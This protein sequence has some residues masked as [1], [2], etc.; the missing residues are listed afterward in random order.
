MLGR[1]LK[2][3]DFFNENDDFDRFSLI[4]DIPRVEL[5]ATISSINHLIKSPLDVNFNNSFENQV[6]LIDAIF[7]THLNVDNRKYIIGFIKILDEIFKNKKGNVVLFTRVSCLYALNEIILTDKIANEKVENYVFHLPDCENIFK[8]LLLNNKELLNYSANYNDEMSS[9]NLGNDFFKAFM[10]K[11][12]PHN[13]YYY[14]QNPINLLNRAVLLFEYLKKT[15]NDELSE[16]LKEYQIDSPEEF[17][18]IIGQFFMS[19]G[20]IPSLQCFKVPLTDVATITRLD[21][22]SQR[23]AGRP[24]IGLKKFEFL[25]IKKSPFYKSAGEENNIYLLMDNIFFIEKAYDLFYWDFFFDKLA[26]GLNQRK[27]ERALKKWGGVVGRFF[28]E[29]LKSILKYSFSEHKDIILKCT[30]ELL[31]DNGDEFADFY[32][33]RKRQVVVGQAKCS[34]LPQIGYKEVYSLDD[35]SNIS[36][37][38]FFCRFGLYQLVDTTIANFREYAHQIDQ[39]L[40]ENKVFI[41]PVLITNEPIMASGLTSQVF[42]D[43]FNNLLIKKGLSMDNE[44]YRINRLVVMHISEL[45]RLQESLK[46]KDFKFDNLLQSYNDKTNV[47]LSRNVYSQFMS[48]DNFIRKKIKEKAIPK[49]IIERKEGIFKLMIDFLNLK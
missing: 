42:N 24:T 49:Y 22:L 11:E 26:I 1:I 39:G 37:E 12:I 7:L 20:A 29:Y 48:F 25:E 33:R 2:F 35:Y 10:F 8:F 19:K 34:F 5:I 6:K 21:K 28:E 32:I 41:Y 16:H 40:S 44:S 3:N 18:G 15:Y 43:K 17:I 31:V 13:Q 27:R 4:E 47:E 30:D 9:D 45:E 23:G 14:I 38:E 36:Q 46:D